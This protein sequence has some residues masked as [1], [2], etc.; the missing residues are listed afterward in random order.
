MVLAGILFK[1]GAYGLLRLG[2][3]FLPRAVLPTWPRC[4]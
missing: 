1:L 2:V 4:S 3:F